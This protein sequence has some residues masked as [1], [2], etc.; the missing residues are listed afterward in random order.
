MT[1][2]VVRSGVFGDDVVDAGG[3]R[4]GARADHGIAK[5]EQRKRRKLRI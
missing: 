3:A 1:M 4:Q 2:P 5:P